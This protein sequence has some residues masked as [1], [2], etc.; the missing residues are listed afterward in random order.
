M[1]V[2]QEEPSPHFVIGEDG[3]V[4]LGDHYWNDFSQAIGAWPIPDDLVE[5]TAVTVAAMHA[6][7][8]RRG[9]VFVPLFVPAKAAVYPDKLPIGTRSDGPRLRDALIV[10][11]ARKG[12]A[13]LDLLPPLVEARKIADGFS[14]LNSHWNSFGGWVVWKAIN[15]HILDHAGRPLTDPAPK[16]CRVTCELEPPEF[17]EWPRNEHNRESRITEADF[18]FGDSDLIFV[19]AAGERSG[20]PPSAQVSLED[21]PLDVHNRAAANAAKCLVMGDSMASNLSPWINAAFSQVH[22]RNHHLTNTM[23]AAVLSDHV[24]TLAPN[25]VFYVIADR[26]CTVAF[27]EEDFW[28]AVDLFDGHQWTAEYRW[29]SDDP[30][31]L[32]VV[33]GREALGTPNLVSLPAASNAGGV[34]LKATVVADGQGLVMSSYSLD[35]TPVQKWH[36]IGPGR[37]AIY[38]LMD[39]PV[40]NGHF[41]LVRDPEKAGAVL[42]D[43]VVRQVP[44]LKS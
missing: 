5:A 3:W 17:P 7:C 6:Y 34:V 15:A 42:V 37:N 12:L 28:R 10:G 26:Y 11:C 2:L 31:N 8:A 32:I 13:V 18:P 30:D 21:F 4:F 38:V 23:A 20:S 1:R 33:S 41:W 24:D 14:K 43:I 40:D 19:N 35:G 44:S 25:F 36:K 29:R 9:I 27:H 22:Y 16:H 39:R